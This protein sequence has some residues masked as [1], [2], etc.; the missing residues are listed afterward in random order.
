MNIILPNK[1]R[2]VWKELVWGESFSQKSAN[3][4]TFYPIFSIFTPK[5]VNFCSF[6][7]KNANLDNFS[8]KKCNFEKFSTS[9][10]EKYGETFSKNSCRPGKK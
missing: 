7:P 5:F 1:R 2:G 9:E 8:P 10:S 3:F 4:H 6:I